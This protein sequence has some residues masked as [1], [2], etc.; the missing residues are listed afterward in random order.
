MLIGLVGGDAAAGQFHSQKQFKKNLAIQVSLTPA[1]LQQLYDLGVTP[2]TR[3]R[4][5]YFYYTDTE[6]KAASL[7]EAL[8]ALGYSGEYGRSASDSS[9]FIVTGWSTPVLMTEATAVEW[10]EQMCRLGFEH[11]AEFD[12]W[13]T[14]PQ[15]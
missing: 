15:Q 7:Y 13:G 14:N 2:Q 1:T 10:T 6:Q 9:I 11:D 4:L 12:G 8:Q 3:L 5:E